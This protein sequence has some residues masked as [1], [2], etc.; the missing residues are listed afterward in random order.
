MDKLK[1]TKKQ[2]AIFKSYLRG[3]LVSFLTFLASNELGFE[4]AISI[5]IAAFAGPAAKAL[6]KSEA[7]YGIGSK[8]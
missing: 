7:E 2:K 5:A 8:E 3:V 6:D 4:P 1:L